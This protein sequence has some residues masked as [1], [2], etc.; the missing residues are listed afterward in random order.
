MHSEFFGRSPV[1]RIVQDL[2]RRFDI[3]LFGANNLYP[4]EMHQIML[5]SPLVKSTVGVLADFIN[6]DGFENGEVTVN[7]IPKKK[8]PV[9]EYL[10]KQGRF[11]HLTKAQVSEIQ[12]ET[13]DNYY[14]LLKT[15]SKGT[16]E[17]G[18]SLT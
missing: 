17:E 3:T 5:R 15:G 18:N 7:R 11:S 2:D 8:R 10:T 16:Q 4:Q 6:G 12:K 9:E 14:R 13:D 1:R